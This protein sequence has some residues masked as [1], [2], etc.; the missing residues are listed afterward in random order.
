MIWT[1]VSIITKELGPIEH[2]TPKQDVS[3]SV[4]ETIDLGRNSLSSSLSIF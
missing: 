2:G 4:I 1:R 3:S